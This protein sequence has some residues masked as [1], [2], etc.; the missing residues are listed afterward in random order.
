M[1]KKFEDLVKEI[2]KSQ[3]YVCLFIIKERE[4]KEK[5][6]EEINYFEIGD[7]M[8]YSCVNRGIF[9]RQ[10]V[11]K[12]EQEFSNWEICRVRKVNYF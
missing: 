11:I 9:C 2:R 3:I 5:F 8:E 6:R 1:F 10:F 7:K 12:I 4:K